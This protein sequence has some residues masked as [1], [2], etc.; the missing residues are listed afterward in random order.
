MIMVMRIYLRRLVSGVLPLVVIGMAA[1]IAMPQVAIAASSRTGSLAANEYDTCVLKG[2]QAYCWGSNFSGQ[3]GD[4]S[5]ADSDMPVAVD[6]SG[7]LA[8]KTLTQISTGAD[9]ACALDSSG[10]AYCWGDNGSGELGD[11]N[12]TGSDS[13]VAIDTSGVLAGKTLTQISGGGGFTCALDSTGAAYCWGDNNV[14]QLGNGNEGPITGSDVPVAVLTSGALAGKT[15]TQISAGD[16]GVCGLDSTG[17]VYCWGN[18][19][20]GMFGTDSFDN[21]DVPVA[22]ANA[23]ALAGVPISQIALGTEHMCELDNAGA[24]YCA[25]YNGYGELGDGNT[26]NSREMTAVDTSSALAG[27]SLAQIAVGVTSTCAVSDAGAVYCWGGNQSGVLGNGSSAEGSDVPVA[28]DATGV[29]SG[30][31]LLQ[32][33]VGGHHACAEDTTGL[34]YCWGDNTYGELGDGT[35]TSS[36]VPVLAGTPPP[37][38]VMATPGDARAAVSWTAPALGSGSVTGYTATASPGDETCTTTSATTCTI[39][40]LANGT[41]YTVT[42]VA[43]TTAGDSGPSAPASVTPEAGDS[44]SSTTITSTTPNP[45]V[46][47]PVT[48]AVQLTGQFTGSGDPAPTGTVTVSDGTQS[49]QAS[50]SGSNGVATGS[51]QITEQAPGT[52]SFTASYP[53]DANFNSSQTST[54]ATV[55]V[56][57]APSSTSISSTTSNPVAGQPVTAAVQVTGQF[58]GSSNP[59]PT[60]TVTVS[61]G[62]RSCQASLSGSNGIA[63]G[64]CQITEQAP[65]TYSFTASYPGD[66]SFDSSQTSS[67]ATVTVGQAPSSTSITSTTSNPVVG[68]PVTAAVRVKGEFTGSGDPVPTGTVTV[69]DGTRSCQASLSGSNGIA[70][71]SCQ[72]TEQAPGTY[73]LAASYPGDPR[74]DSSHGTAARVAVAKATSRTSLK[75]SAA[76]V[77][78]GNE[79]TLKLT[80][81]AVPQF[82]GTPGGVVTITAG[83]A[84][85]CT[86]KLSAGT[87]SCSAASA[88]VLNT[89][90][91][92][93]TASYTGSADFLPS[94]ASAALQ[95]R[96]P[97]S[98]TSLTLSPASVAYGHEQSLKLTVTVAPQYSGSPRG[99]VIIAVGQTTLCTIR[100]SAQGGSCSP[101]S[102]RVLTIGKHLIVASYQ[103]SADF[104]ASSTSRTLTV[105]K[106]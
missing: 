67:P 1:G 104:A 82:T 88:T 18:N 10:A 34:V 65:G 46:G 87:G 28:V 86:V 68:Q 41:T 80:A 100:L 29:L 64:S 24:A 78:Y 98:R 20:S 23:G 90:R 72:I 84:T 103:G 37:A 7:V 31:T 44:A 6:T 57:Q 77:V 5:T 105:T 63:T 17:A 26:T 58:T 92:T 61:D 79:K 55:T 50:L 83:Q 49:C 16:Q 48:T 15:L 76:S 12:F 27:Q 99:T 85:M 81:T 45:V 21:S 91:A 11:G 56:G 40:G 89:G 60:G 32:A 4:G 51:C 54:P 30:V 3:L 8:G 95:V 14:G 13:P 73:S 38:G 74:F 94:S 69:S 93:L 9:S 2:G 70:T 42:V 62:T 97:Q 52:Y 96:E 43:H 66:A 33:T 25:G 59:A 102:P 35:T 101:A 19:L 106:A 53:G 36:S 75:L 47:Q 71:G 39:T 22:V